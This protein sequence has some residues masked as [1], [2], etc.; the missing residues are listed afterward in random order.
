LFVAIKDAFRADTEPKSVMSLDADGESTFDAI[1]LK[2]YSQIVSVLLRVVGEVSQ[3]EELAEDVFLKLYER[4]L[5]P[6]A[7]HNIGGWLYRTAVNAGIDALRANSRR[8]RHEEEAGRLR[9]ENVSSED[10]LESLVRAN[11]Q[12]NVREV[13]AQLRPMRV[14]L[15]ILRHSGFSYKEIAEVIGVKH[16]SVGTLLARAEADFEQRYRKKYPREEE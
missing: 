12:R 7:D 11:T 10:P 4:P 3:A 1:F 14:R 13:L 2:H 6:T 16:S 9:L 15:L 8:R 5:P